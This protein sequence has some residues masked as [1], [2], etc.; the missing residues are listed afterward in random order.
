MKI[1]VD[2]DETICT[3][4][5]GDPPDYSQA[6]PLPNNIEKI[7]S[8]YQKEHEIT[9]WTARGSSCREDEEMQAFLYDLTVDQLREWNCLYSELLLTK[10]NYDVIIDDKSF[11]SVD[12]FYNMGQVFQGGGNSY[13]KEDIKNIKNASFVEG[14][15][16]S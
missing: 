16:G 7:N 5:P 10:M 1:F 3:T 6:V 9:Y 12:Q 14:F 2:I 8:C 15:K 13:S 11:N 4:P